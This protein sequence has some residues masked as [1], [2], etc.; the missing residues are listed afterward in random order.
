MSTRTDDRSDR[1]QRHRNAVEARQNPDFMVHAMLHED[2]DWSD[3]S[4][5][6]EYVAA[7]DEDDNSSGTEVDDEDSAETEYLATIAEHVAAMMPPEMSKKLPCYRFFRQGVSGCSAGDK[8]KFSHATDNA[9]MQALYAKASRKVTLR[10]EVPTVQVIV[11]SDIAETI[12]VE[13][14]AETIAHD[15][16]G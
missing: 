5:V 6:E 9:E 11:Q 12:T 1:K 4:E 15:G 14:P 7:F 16:S 10:K 8:C 3:E 2:A 13:V